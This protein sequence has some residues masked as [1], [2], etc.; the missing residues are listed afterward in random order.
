MKIHTHDH[1][2]CFNDTH[3]GI[4]FLKRGDTVPESQL[5][6][7]LLD[8]SESSN[9]H[10]LEISNKWF[11]IS[12]DVGIPLYE[13]MTMYYHGQYDKTVESIFPIRHEIYRIG[14]SNAQLY[15]KYRCAVFELM[16]PFTYTMNNAEQP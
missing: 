9:F 7:S 5:H 1:V 8:F 15:K 4:A 6:S 10:G 14:G 11:L 12:R 13:G 3:L 2:T 16:K